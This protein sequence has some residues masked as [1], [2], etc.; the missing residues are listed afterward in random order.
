MNF[1][2]RGKS[3]SSIERDVERTIVSFEDVPLDALADLDVSDDLDA[4]NPF[5]TSIDVCRWCDGPAS[6]SLDACCMRCLEKLRQ[7]AERREKTVSNGLR[8]DFY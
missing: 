2:P 5:P 4:P 3:R 7:H 6:P 8:V 1:W